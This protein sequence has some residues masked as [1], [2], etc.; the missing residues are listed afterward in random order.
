MFRMGQHVCFQQWFPYFP[1]SLMAS[2]PGV[3]IL[4]S[5]PTQPKGVDRPLYITELKRSLQ[6]S[7]LSACTGRAK[8]CKSE[9]CAV[10]GPVMAA[11]ESLTLPGTK[12]FT[13]HWSELISPQRRK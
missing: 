2:R 8:A 7:S 11:R 12:P 5:L 3:G 1:L 13:P 9:A 4:L 6:K 10:L